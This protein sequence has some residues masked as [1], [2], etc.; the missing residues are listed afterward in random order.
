M[1]WTQHTRETFGQTVPVMLLILIG[2]L[3]I[4]A[5]SFGRKATVQTDSQPVSLFKITYGE[6]PTK[7]RL[8]F[9]GSLRLGEEEEEPLF[10]GGPTTFCVSWDGQLFYIADPLRVYGKD[11]KPPQPSDDEVEEERNEELVPWVQVYNRQGQWVRT[12]KIK[13]GFPS[14]IRVDERGW[15]YVDDAGRGVAVYR[16]DGAYDQQRTEA[17]AAEIRRAETEH[18]LD[19]ELKP[20]FFEVD[21]QGRVYF[22]ANQ[23][24]S[25][26]GEPSISSCVC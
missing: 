21:R 13:Y 23:I 22:L 25:E 6:E 3:A 10:G 19:P 2:M 16:P 12:I 7:L 17:I 15:L 5:A 18:R 14:R 8:R 20:E 26:E 24:V 1:R 11:L 4:A 9:P